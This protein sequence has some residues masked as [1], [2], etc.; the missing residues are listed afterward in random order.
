[1]LRC[2]MLHYLSCTSNHINHDDLRYWLQNASNLQSILIHP[3]Y[4]VRH[5]HK[6]QAMRQLSSSS[7]SSFATEI[8]DHDDDRTTTTTGSSSST[9]R[10][11]KFAHAYHHSRQHHHQHR[12]IHN[13]I[14]LPPLVLF[15]METILYLFQ[16]T[17][18]TSQFNWFLFRIFLLIIDWVIAIQLYQLVTNLL[19][20]NMQQDTISTDDTTTSS[21]RNEIQILQEQMNPK[22]HPSLRM[23]QLIPISSSSTFTTSTTVTKT[24]TAMVTPIL[25]LPPHV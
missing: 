7:S 3:I 13:Q 1:M 11:F 4:T 24:M 6:A 2:L 19:Y 12:H 21:S 22:L 17:T 20:S 10:R 25:I 8:Y 5:I 23:L 18:S 16:T 9:S 14:H 15:V